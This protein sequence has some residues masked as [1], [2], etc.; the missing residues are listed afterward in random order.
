MNEL[1]PLDQ[2]AGEWEG[3]QGL[4]VA[5]SHDLGEVHETPY[6]EKLSLKPF[7]P[8]VNG[9]QTLYGLDYKTAAW[10]EGQDN[11]FHTEV[12]Y[13]LWCAESGDVMRCMVIPR[14][15][16]VMAGGTVAPDATS[17]TLHADCG[18]EEFGIMSNPYL[19]KQAR[20]VTYDVTITVEG[21]T[22]TYESNTVIDLA[23]MDVPL[24]HTDRNTLTRV[25]R[26]EL[27]V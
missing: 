8:V 22:F 24:E 9:K 12:G 15:T 27:A 1:G 2:L 17:F 5:F 16:V 26:Y 14:G 4:D 18:S 7:G 20:T 25:E 11:P 19:A 23:R 13:W 10:R 6:R 3:D 21:D